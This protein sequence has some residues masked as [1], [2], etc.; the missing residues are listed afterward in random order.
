MM[1]FKYKFLEDFTLKALINT[2][3]NDNPD[4]LVTVCMCSQVCG[5]LDQQAIWKVFDM[6]MT[7]NFED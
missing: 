5:F 2:S 7:N 6:V 1:S 3:P 4:F